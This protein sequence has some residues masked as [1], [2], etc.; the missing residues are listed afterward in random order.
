MIYNYIEII[1]AAWQK[2]LRFKPPSAHINRP[3][4]QYNRVHLGYMQMT[5]HTMVCQREM[6]YLL[7][8]G[9]R[10]E[11]WGT[12][13]LLL[14]RKIAIQKRQK[15]TRVYTFPVKEFHFDI[16]DNPGLFISYDKT[17]KHKSKYPV[18]YLYLCFII[19]YKNIRTL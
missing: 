2:L 14:K 8:L 19:T 15:A 13:W 17:R 16:C 11:N 4:L 9:S 12:I 7:L 6:I 1:H 3:V 5:C 18:I 10:R